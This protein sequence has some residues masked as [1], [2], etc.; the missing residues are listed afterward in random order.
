MVVELRIIDSSWLCG[1]RGNCAARFYQVEVSE[2]ERSWLVERRYKDFLKLHELLAGEGRLVR[3]QLPPKGFIGLRHY[4]NIGRFNRDRLK[5][6]RDYLLI[7]SRQLSTVS[8]SDAIAAFTSAES[9][10]GHWTDKLKQCPGCAP[11]GNGDR[12]GSTIP[13]VASGAD[14]SSVLHDSNSCCLLGRGSCGGSVLAPRASDASV[15]STQAETDAEGRD[16]KR[17]ASARAS[18]KGRV[19]IRLDAF[20]DADEFEDSSW[21]DF[22]QSQPEVADVIKRVALLPSSRFEN[23]AEEMFSLLR[24][25]LLRNRSLS[26]PTL[27]SRSERRR[28]KSMKLGATASA[29][30]LQSTAASG[31]GASEDGYLSTSSMPEGPVPRELLPSTEEADSMLERSVDSTSSELQ[32]VLARRWHEVEGG[33]TPVQVERADIQFNVDVDSEVTD[34]LDDCGRTDSLLEDPRR[35]CV[36]SICETGEATQ[37][38]GLES[39]SILDEAPGKCA[40]WRFLLLL[41]ARRPVLRRRAREVAGLLEANAKWRDALEGRP[42]LMEAWHQVFGVYCHSTE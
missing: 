14:G 29:H 38:S 33:Q 35:D 18:V 5:G 27:R 42:D 21:E 19:N 23:D 37:E 36:D 11:P 40:V 41:A 25:T 4:L 20:G 15:P 31:E 8:G 22:H 26:V 13:A 24:R 3:A 1:G 30:S 34:Q 7:L 12:S 28:G 2:E 9:S 39:C 6:L 10:G 32:Q 17:T 16:C